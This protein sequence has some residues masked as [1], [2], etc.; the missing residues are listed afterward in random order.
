MMGKLS[1]VKLNNNEIL[2]AQ[3]SLLLKLNHTQDL[4]NLQKLAFVSLL[5]YFTFSKFYHLFYH[6]LS[7]AFKSESHLSQ[8]L[9][10]FCC[11]QGVTMRN[12]AFQFVT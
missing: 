7:V 9:F 2:A 10:C 4:I 3:N 5:M 8:C 6:Q 12:P 11:M 1:E